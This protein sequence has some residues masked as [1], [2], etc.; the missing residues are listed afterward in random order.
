MSN[1]FYILYLETENNT[2]NDDSYGNDND[3]LVVLYKF[4]TST[5]NN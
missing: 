2:N 5:H 1:N 3:L 4:S